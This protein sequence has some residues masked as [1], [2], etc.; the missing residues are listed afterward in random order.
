[1]TPGQP[2][3]R[4]MRHATHQHSK[5]V[6]KHEIAPRRIKQ[7]R[8]SRPQANKEQWRRREAAAE[9]RIKNTNKNRPLVVLVNDLSG[10]PFRQLSGP[11]SVFLLRALNG[12]SLRATE[13]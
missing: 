8:P 9:G 2:V 7:I 4:L 12:E 1:M 6:F 11:G 5:L 3:N 10:Q 13:D